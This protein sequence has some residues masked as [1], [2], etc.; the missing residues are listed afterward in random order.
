M[1][2]VVWWNLRFEC[3]AP[4]PEMRKKFH[5]EKK[6]TKDQKCN[7]YRTNAILMRKFKGNKVK[8][9]RMKMTTHRETS[10]KVNVKHRL[11]EHVASNETEWNEK[12]CE[13]TF[14][15]EFS[16]AHL[17]KEKKMKHTRCGK[18]P[19]KTES[20]EMLKFYQIQI[21]PIRNVC[22]RR[23]TENQYVIN[24][25]IGNTLRALCL[26][27]ARNEKLNI[28][29]SSNSTKT[30]Y[31]SIIICMTTDKVLLIRFWMMHSPSLS[32]YPISTSL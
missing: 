18:E 22:E 9:K 16:T 7:W 27:T 32:S 4:P 28:S 14:A 29:S 31:E 1:S 6:G 8:G 5:V 20:I 23:T 13:S 30:Q 21:A 24:I 10:N 17:V 12:T 3:F 11:C 15:L 19:H 26:M 25:E 2:F